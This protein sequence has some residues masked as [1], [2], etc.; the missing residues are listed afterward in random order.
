VGFSLK[1][2][3]AEEFERANSRLSAFSSNKVEVFVDDFASNTKPGKTY[4]GTAIQAAH[5]YC[6]SKGGGKVRLTGKYLTEQ[7]L[8]SA[9]KVL[10]AG[11]SPFSDGIV[12]ADD[13]NDHIIETEGFNNLKGTNSWLVSEGV[14]YGFGLF[15]MFLDG[16][17]A[18]NTAGRGWNVYGKG[19][20]YDRLIIFNTAQE[21]WYSEC[22]FKGGQEGVEDLPEGDMGSMF[23][24]RPGQRGAG[25]S[26]GMIYKGPHDGRIRSVVVA[27][28]DGYGAK[29]VTDGATY[30]GKCDVDFMHVYGCYGKGIV[31]SAGGTATHL[32]G[33]SCDEEG[34]L[35]AGFAAQIGKTEAYRNG[36]R[37]V[38]TG[39]E[40][41]A[42]I[43]G[44]GHTIGHIETRDSGNA[45]G[46]VH[47]S[48]NRS[49]ITVHCDGQ[50]KSGKTGFRNTGKSNKIIGH[51]NGFNLAGG[52]AL[53][54]S[55]D[56]NDYDFTVDDCTTAINVGAAAIGVHAR[57]RADLKEGQSLFSGVEP[58]SG[59]ALNKETSSWSITARVG[60]NLFFTR[61]RKKSGAS[62]D[63]TGA[64]GSTGVITI[65]H[66]IPFPPD[67]EDVS[68]GFVFDDGAGGTP[69]GTPAAVVSLIGQPTANQCSFRYTIISSGS[70]SD[71]GFVTMSIRY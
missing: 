52:R 47:C 6:K 60:Q 57:I 34:V 24:Y 18:N 1:I 48:A 65:A 49:N 4:M 31:W 32:I 11:F 38:G 12:L 22:A 28:S 20:F 50:G 14:P 56:W 40:Y 21:G 35:V 30:N 46:G 7:K 2:S 33:E 67:P 69:A 16:N 19:Y 61:Q 63:A 43:E 41:N 25:T 9:S 51:V 45:E 64:A 39:R 62:F 15:D 13:V 37:S 10:F 68:Y 55:G 29:F 54:L 71:R 3:T 17:K 70:A 8:V 66:N 36:I 42:Y 58:V 53:D 23:I 26:H 27:S 5:D 44:A 59:A